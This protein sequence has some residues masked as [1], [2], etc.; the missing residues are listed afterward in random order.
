MNYFNKI[1]RNHLNFQ[2]VP[3]L[4]IINNLTHHCQLFNQMLVI[5][6]ADLKILKNRI[7]LNTSHN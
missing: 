3:I 2:F 4:I 7:F 5:I 1:I 6:N